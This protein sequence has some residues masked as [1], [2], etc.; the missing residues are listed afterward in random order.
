MSGCQDVLRERFP[1][2][3][4]YMT[5]RYPRTVLFDIFI[6]PAKGSACR[7][8]QNGAH[9]AHARQETALVADPAAVHQQHTQQHRQSHYDEQPHRND[10]LRAGIRSHVTWGKAQERTAQGP[11]P[12][13]QGKR[14]HVLA[15]T[16]VTASFVHSAHYSHPAGGRSDDSVS[17]RIEFM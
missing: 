11:P 16:T 2:R 12:V 10:G 15:A 13:L 5:T 17:K 8:A 1:G 4:H 3:S 6:D 14:R 9:P 7:E